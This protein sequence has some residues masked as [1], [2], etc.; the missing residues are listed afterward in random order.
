MPTA[1]VTGASRGLGLALARSLAADGWRLVI[2][3]RGREG[4]RPRRGVA[5]RA[6]PRWSRSPAT[7]PTTGTDAASSAPPAARS[8]CWSTTPRSSARAP[9]RSS[10]RYPLAEL[11]RVYE[12]NVVAPLALVQAALPQ[13]AAGA[14]DPQRHLRRRGRGLPRLGRLRLGEGGARAAR[15]DAR[16]RAPASCAS[17]PS[18]P[19]TCEPA[20]TRRRSRARTSPTARRRARRVPALRELIDGELPERALPGGGAGAGRTRERPGV[21]PAGGARGSRAARGARAGARRGQADG[22]HPLATG[23]SRTRAS[24]TCPSSWCPATCW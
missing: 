6:A 17:T 24:A 12:V 18:T 1:I 16:R 14:P 21:R 15:R 2:D 5:R 23:A 11:R 9:S 7:S 13:L 8:T 22:R 3:A 10:A 4:A 19:A 20:C